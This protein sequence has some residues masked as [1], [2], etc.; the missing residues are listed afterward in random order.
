M[1]LPT[2]RW[3]RLTPDNINALPNADGV[4]EVANLVRNVQF[5]G[6]GCGRLRDTVTT[7]GCMPRTLPLSV[8][9]YFFRYELTT[10]EGE[11]FKR[12]IEAYRKRHDGAVPPGNASEF[13]EP[14]PIAKPAPAERPAV[15]QQAA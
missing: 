2:G 4:F 3:H 8:G 5:V 7:F 12:R 1:Q 15:A 11:T 9:G 10:A 6:R 13:L 14:T